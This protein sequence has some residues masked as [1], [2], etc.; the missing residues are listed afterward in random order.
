MMKNMCNEELC[1]KTAT[2]RFSLLSCQLS[3]G[4]EKT[5]RQHGLHVYTCINIFLDRDYSYTYN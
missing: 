4:S 1:F 2:G 3:L 5:T